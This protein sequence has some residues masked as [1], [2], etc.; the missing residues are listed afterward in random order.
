MVMISSK[1]HLIKSISLIL[2][3]KR[4]IDEKENKVKQIFDVWNK[5]LL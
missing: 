3:K 1:A 2:K 4:K 5:G